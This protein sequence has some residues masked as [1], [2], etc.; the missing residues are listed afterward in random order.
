MI[1]GQPFNNIAT[2]FYSDIGG[3]RFNGNDGMA[4]LK[5]MNWEGG[6]RVPLLITWGNKI[7]SQK[8]NAIVSNFD[9]I[10]TMAD[11]LH[12]P[13]HE[14]ILGL[15]YLPLLFNKP[16]K[17]EHQYI[18]NGSFMGPQMVTKDRW[19]LRYFIPK[20]I[21]QLYYL[22]DDYRQEHNMIDKDPE[23]AKGLEKLLLTACDGNYNNGWYNGP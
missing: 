6:V 1:T 9:F 23:E 10:S 3:D 2:K 21:F 8:A 14:K 13:L 15:S 22:P 5:R 17:K 12:V 19:K 16:L 20:N 4:G 18:V 7:K 11:L